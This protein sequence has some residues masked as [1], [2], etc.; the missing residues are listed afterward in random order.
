M[1]NLSFIKLLCLIAAL[2]VLSVPSFAQTFTNLADFNVADGDGPYYGPLVQGFDGSFY[3][4]TIFGGGYKNGNV[5]EVSPAGKVTN[6]YSFCA[7]RGCPDGAEPQNGVILG[8]NGGL[9]GTTAGGGAHGA[10]TIFEI[11]PNAQFKTI[12][13][14]CSQANCADGG[15]PEKLVLGQNGNLYGTAGM[16]GAYSNGTVFEITPAGQLTTLYSFCATKNAQGVCKDGA[17]P[18]RAFILGSDGNF[19]G[20]TQGGGSPN[21]NIS[22]L[23]PGCGTF[24]KM[25]PHGQLNAYSLFNGTNGDDPVSL[26]QGSDG[27]FYGTTLVG[28]VSSTCASQGY[29]GGCGTVF[30]I[31]PGG[32]LTTLHDF[33]LSTQCSDGLAPWNLIQATDGNFYGTS[34]G[35]VP[36]IYQL[37]P[38]G[39]FTTL[40]TFCDQ[41][42]GGLTPYGSLFQG[43]NGNLYGTTFEGFKAQQYGTVYRLSMGLG[44]SVQSSPTFGK[45]GYNIDI[46]GNGLTGT[47]S[48][49]FNGVSAMFNVIS[50]THIKATVP[51]GSTTGTVDVTTPNGMLSS[52]VSFDVIP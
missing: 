22:G 14:F 47:T 2:S 5:Y 52:N 50:S 35:E 4:S 1:R 8:P 51:S 49:T 10:G 31:T 48:V 40:Y 46:L 30:Q 20:T 6:L 42:N 39:N 16:Y 3:G 41:C 36:L 12:Y 23:A 7:T 34:N 43:T 26:L 44:P 9:Y 33:C 32:T 13:S 28:G 37:T 29:S 18:G 38:A 19:Y 25:T 17:G 21:C 11:L 15:G 45:V 27:N 24:F